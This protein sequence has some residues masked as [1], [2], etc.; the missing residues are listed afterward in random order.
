MKSVRNPM[1]HIG[2]RGFASLSPTF[3]I[4]T[5]LVGLDDDNAGIDAPFCWDPWAKDFKTN[6]DRDAD[7]KRHTKTAGN[8]TIIILLSIVIDLTVTSLASPVDIL[9]NQ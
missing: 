6:P 8:R 2:A 5:F 7:I 4:I 3:S 1:L 9:R